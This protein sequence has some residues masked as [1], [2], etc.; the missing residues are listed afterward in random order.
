MLYNDQCKLGK[1]IQRRIEKLR[2]ENK[3]PS[4][5]QKSAQLPIRAP[6]A[7]PSFDLGTYSPRAVPSPPPYGRGR[8][9][10]SQATVD[11]SFMVLGGRVSV[12]FASIFSWTLIK[13]NNLRKL[14]PIQVMILQSF[15]L[16]CKQCKTCWNNH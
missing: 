5:P 7:S 16:A 14:S 11:E 6:H 1:E 15:G 12:A 2:S 10:D 9:M 13:F 8:M 4:L 3:D